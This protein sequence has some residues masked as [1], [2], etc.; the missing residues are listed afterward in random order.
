MRRFWFFLVLFLVLFISRD[1]IFGSEATSSAQISPPSQEIPSPIPKILAVAKSLEGAPY[2]AAGENPEG[3]DCSGFVGYVF[4][5][6]GLKL[7]RNSQSL[8]TWKPHL[9][10]AAIQPGDLLYFTGSDAS[11]SR[12]GHVALV[13]SHSQD[14]L[15][16]IHA[17]NRGVVIDNLKTMPYYLKRYLGANRPWQP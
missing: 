14:K 12:A 10:S 17:T 5:Q 9:D 1:W 16:M 15:E 7:P 13:V 3:F 8:M 4:K 6:E 2:K 11:S